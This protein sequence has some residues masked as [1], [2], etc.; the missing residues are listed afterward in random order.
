MLI[1]SA[2]AEATLAHIRKIVGCMKPGEYLEVDRYDLYA[3][4]AYEHNDSTFT[5]ADR[6]LGGIMGSTYTHS[7]ELLMNGNI[8][9]IRHEDKGV[10][11]YKEPDHDIRVE[12]LKQRRLMP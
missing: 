4:P 2:R 7:F 5:A 6:V 9:F 8:R 12:R 11:R 1:S 3:I 10:R